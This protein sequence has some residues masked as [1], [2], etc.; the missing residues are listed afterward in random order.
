MSFQV[1][2]LT[3]DSGQLS[4]VGRQRNLVAGAGVWAL[5]D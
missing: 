2:A 3:E 5:F 4:G 1:E